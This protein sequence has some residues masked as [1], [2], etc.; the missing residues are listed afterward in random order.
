MVSSLLTWPFISFLQ[1]SYCF[2]EAQYNCCWNANYCNESCQ[3]AHWPEHSS[4]CMQVQ[5]Q[6]QQ[7]SNGGPSTARLPPSSADSQKI[8]SPANSESNSNVF[9]FSNTSTEQVQNEDVLSVRSASIT[10]NNQSSSTLPSS[11]LE[12][13]NMGLYS[14]TAGIDRRIRN[15]VHQDNAVVITVPE[16]EMFSISD[17]EMEQHT[18]L[19]EQCPNTATALLSHTT[20][21]IISQSVPPHHVIPVSTSPSPLA[22]N[23]GRPI[24]PATPPPPQVSEHPPSIMHMG[25]TFSWPY[26]QPMGPPMTHDFT[27]NLPL[28]PQ[29]PALT[30]T[31]Q[32]N[33]FF[34]VF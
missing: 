23:S 24:S 30:P 2:K 26:Q 9:S 22:L 10:N 17:H 28:L 21:P 13:M 7:S 11:R 32:S 12:D 14:S 29:V 1:C 15:S 19:I 33:T 34:R 20:S 25:N 31:T 8:F 18:V 16:K 3:Q 4:V 5:N 6:N 27:Q